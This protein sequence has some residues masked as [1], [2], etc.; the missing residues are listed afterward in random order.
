MFRINVFMQ[1]SR[2]RTIL[3]A[4]LL[5][6][7]P[8][9]ITNAAPLYQD[10]PTY[11]VG[12]QPHSIALDDFNGDGN[13]DSAVANAGAG[14]VSVSLG[15][16][17]GTF[18]G[19]IDY[20]VGSG[21]YAIIAGQ[22]NTAVDFVPDLV[23]ANATG[24]SLSVLLGNGDGTFAAAVAYGTGSGSV[25]V[26]FD[27]GS[28]NGD[29]YIDLV[30]A[31]DSGNVTVMLGDG[32][33]ALTMGASYAAGAN[34]RS[35]ASTDF[36]GDGRSDIAAASYSSKDITV[37]F[38]NGDGT[39]VLGGALP[40]QYSPVSLAVGDFD[41]DGQPDLVAGTL[42]STSVLLNDGL[43]GFGAEIQNAADSPAYTVFAVDFDGDGIKDVAGADY[44]F[45]GINLWLGNG[46]GTLRSAISYA[47]DMRTAALAAADIDNDGRVDFV[48]ASENAG[49]LAVLIAAADGFLQAPRA[50]PNAGTPADQIAADFNGDGIP[51]LATT[52]DS[53]GFV[54]IMLG[55]ADGSLSPQGNRSAGAGANAIAAGRF[56][57][58]P[59]IDLAVVNE[60]AS[61]VSVFLGNGDGT[62][63]ARTD[64]I[65]GL[66]GSFPS[67]IAVDDFDGDG[68]DD[69]A[70]ASSSYHIVETYRADSSGSG[71]F[72]GSNSYMVGQRPTGISSGDFNAD[73]LPD[74]AVTGYD[75]NDVSILLGDTANPGV[76]GT[77]VAYSVGNAPTAIV[78]GLFN[79]DAALDL[80]VANSG[81]GTVTLLVG[82]G[83]GT[84]ATG[85]TA[86]VGGN[87]V[88]MVVGQYDDKTGFD[89]AV[90]NKQSNSVT[91]LLGRGDGTF[92][93]GD[94]LFTGRF[95]APMSIVAA[96]FDGDGKPELSVA[97]SNWRTIA[98]YS[99]ISDRGVLSFSAASASVAENAGSASITV[100]RTGG[101]GTTSIRYGT[102]GGNAVAGV[103]YTSVAGKL[104]F[105]EGETSK[106]ITI[107]INDDSS[108]DGDLSF[109]VA[110]SDPLPGS[111]L[112]AHTIMS[113]TITD[114]ESEAQQPSDPSD[115]I[116]PSNPSYPINPSYPTGPASSHPATTTPQE[117]TKP[118][119]PPAAEKPS[120]TDIAGHW[121]E[122]AILD[123]A[124]AGWAH[125][126]P[127][128]T[129]QPNRAVT[130]AEF[131]VMLAQVLGLEGEGAA[132]TFADID[133]IGDWA[134]P[135]IG[136]GV[137]AGIIRGYPNGTF[138]PD[139]LISRV[140]MAKMLETLYKG[141]VPAAERTGFADDEDI[142]AW[143]R[144]AVEAG[145]VNGIIRGR[146]DN[147]FVPDGLATRAEAVTLLQN[148]RR[149]LD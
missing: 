110:L 30:V 25:P 65:L 115:P 56:D 74:L 125:G 29:T 69:F 89:L 106:S 104:V 87:P 126:Y 62:F 130:R 129:F 101:A 144:G 84:F 35:I 21:P 63:G 128:R 98:V 64:Y 109:L 66:T 32:S 46:D 3:L 136:R 54:T 55:N 139:R 58:G 134:I 12:V 16:G 36:D 81:D 131:A 48:A 76:F 2:W 140:E 57:A 28:F 102:T 120:F 42:Q 122:A 119:Q 39:F 53:L 94:S 44:N 79:G 38:G 68:Y 15:E 145:R 132:L 112:G 5:T 26:D 52:L 4:L 27:T 118:E 111:S 59:T 60:N 80:A 1:R 100:T 78:S 124:A 108:E 137:Q 82:A 34:P 8:A 10:V 105:H 138:Q 107:P 114:D 121:G 72:G 24:S 73:G 88:A 117:P 61:T 23:V 31:D 135:A 91:L 17:D 127:D 71:V 93:Q 49:N 142:P 70:I 133:D 97:N 83:D 11:G 92:A 22:F 146:G 37:M 149:L 50:Y 9:A 148:L 67:A 116:D 43:G 33:G 85:A 20:P 41:D 51:D 99:P 18:A 96:D 90:A 19:A 13:M 40:L 95:S 123:A 143:A 45:H 75:S 77:A 6:L 141:G 113:L 147:R 14:T 47:A 103:D 7:S 86:A